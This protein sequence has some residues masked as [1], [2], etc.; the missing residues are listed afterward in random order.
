[1]GVFIL[2]THMFIYKGL[3]WGENCNRTICRIPQ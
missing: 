1:V 2:P 3:L